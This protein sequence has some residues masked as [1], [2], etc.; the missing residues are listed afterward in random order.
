ML[1]QHL[2]KLPLPS[3]F[4][5]ATALIVRSG[6]EPSALALPDS[7]TR[8]QGLRTDSLLLPAA[9]YVRLFD[10]VWRKALATPTS[11]LVAVPAPRQAPAALFIDIVGAACSFTFDSVAS[12]ESRHRRPSLS[13]GPRGHHDRGHRVPSAGAST[14]C[15]LVRGVRRAIALARAFRSH[16]ARRLPRSFPGPLPTVPAASASRGWRRCARRV[17]FAPDTYDEAVAARVRTESPRH[18]S[19]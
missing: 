2:A 12:K 1:A 8:L 7:L 16:K 14:R 4:R 11:D 10:L 6:R 5:Q 17:T 19:Q 3:G 9:T 18:C 13:T 15:A